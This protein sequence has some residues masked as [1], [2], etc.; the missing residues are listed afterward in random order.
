MTMV[1]PE[2]IGL[3]V[4]ATVTESPFTIDDGETVQDRLDDILVTTKYD[5]TLTAP[6]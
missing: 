5:P 1:F 6:P 2:R 3:M 4:P